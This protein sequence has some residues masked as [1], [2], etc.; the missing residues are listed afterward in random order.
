ML[1]G[2]TSLKPPLEQG[3]AV[4]VAVSVGGGGEGVRVT[5][6]V[7]GQTGVKCSISV[8]W[9]GS[10]GCWEPTAQTLLEETGAIP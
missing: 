10:V 1:P 7:G 8:R 5:V 6:A 2:G 9:G 3:V 4:A